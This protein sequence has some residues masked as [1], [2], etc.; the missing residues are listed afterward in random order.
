MGKPKCGILG[1]ALAAALTLAPTSRAAEA[2]LAP[3]TAIATPA[4]CGKVEDMA[5]LNRK[6]G[7][8]PAGQAAMIDARNV[9]QRWAAPDGRWQLMLV[10]AD[11]AA[12]DIAAGQMWQGEPFLPSEGS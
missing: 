3:D 5:A 7:Y 1:L 6:H 10:R 11:G 9:V 4:L 8:E 12:C 2:P